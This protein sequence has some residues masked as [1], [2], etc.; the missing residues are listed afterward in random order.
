LTPIARAIAGIILIA[1][2]SVAFA[3]QQAPQTARLSGRVVAADSNT[4]VRSA[5]LSLTGATAGLA[6]KVASTDEEGRFDL[7]DVPVGTYTLQI[8]KSGFVTS[9]FG[10]KPGAEQFS[11]SPG[12]HVKVDDLRLVRAGAVSGRILDAFGEPIA[13]VAVT[14]WRVQ[15]LTPA[16]RRVVSTRSFRTNDLGE[17]RVYGLQ[18][19]QYFISASR[20]AD[21][22]IAL[23]TFYPG[24]GSAAEATAVDLKGG[25]DVT[26]IQIQL[27]RVAYGQVTG[28]VTTSTARPYDSAVVWLI[29]ARADDALFSN[30]LM[31]TTDAQGQFRIV[32]V[33]PGT[34]SV[35]VFSRAWT[36]KVAK[37]GSAS[38]GP[39]GDVGNAPVTVTPGSTQDVSV[40]TSRG[41]RVRGRVIVDGD[42]A[43]AGSSARFRVA[44]LP[45]RTAISAMSVPAVA[46][47]GPDGSFVLE[48]VYG[49]RIIRLQ[50][51]AGGNVPPPPPPPPPP[52]SSTQ[53]PLPAPP[54]AAGRGPATVSTLLR[55]MWRGN[56]V[57]DQGIALTADIDGLEVHVTS[58]PSRVEGRAVTAAGE[59]LGPYT[60]VV[61][62]V[63]RNEWMRPHARKYTTVESKAGGTFVLT[64]LPAGNYLAALLSDATR[65]R[66]ADPDYLDSLRPVATPFTVTDGQTT[67]ITLQ[68]RR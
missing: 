55:V 52:S 21:A 60:A 36:E 30:G 14:A 44:A 3:R 45:A 20:T 6:T 16:Q 28:T 19:G 23:P 18:P 13:D 58:Q 65:D 26:G 50:S 63:D 51:A 27:T 67:T 66:W 12:Q 46:D 31:A 24:T 15:F 35:E 54:G 22:L 42:G 41:F 43:A 49:D 2:A 32:N 38:A 29:P 61:F 33:S 59:A 47:V 17:F 39:P 48:G 7:Q 5:D 57:T 56:D 4:P 25:Q 11:L 40:Q 68:V 37:T 9:T 64:G 10:P 1:F 62:S 8:S 34:Y 53:A